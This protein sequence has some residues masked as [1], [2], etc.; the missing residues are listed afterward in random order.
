LYVKLSQGTARRDVGQEAAFYTEAGSARGR[1]YAQYEV[2]NFARPG[3]E[4]RHNLNTWRMQEWIGLGRRLRRS[5]TVG[6]EQSGRLDA[7]LADVAGGR[8]AAAERVDSLRGCWWRMAWYSAARMNEGVDLPALRAGFR[9][10]PG[11]DRR[12]GRPVGG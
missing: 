4:C 8:R 12:A 11:R 3:H 7:W 5:R 1:G 10:R 6:G 9:Q 2:S